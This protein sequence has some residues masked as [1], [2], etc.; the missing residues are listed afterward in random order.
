M[1][2]RYLFLLFI[3]IGSLYALSNEEILKRA[4][5]YMQSG[6]QSDQFRA[7]DDYKN[8]YLRAMVE[9]DSEL[10]LNSLR[11][12]V[13]SGNKLHIDV[14]RYSKELDKISPK[15]SYNKPTS[16]PNKKSKRAKDIHIKSSHKLTSI[17]WKDG[18]LVLDFDKKLRENQVN[19]FTLYDSK[20][21]IYKY[22]F[23]IHAS[24]LTKS[25]N[26]TKDGID[27]IKLAQ[28]KPDTLR[29]VI[30]NS[31]KIK[32][33]F[34]KEYSGL[35]IN[36]KSDKIKSIAKKILPPKRVDRSK[37]I[38]IDAGHGGRDPGAVGY[39]KYREKIVVFKIA[40]ELK[41]I[42]ISRGYK[43]Y[44]TRDRDKHVKL[45]RRTKFANEKNADIFISIHA[46]AVGKKNANKVNGIESYFLSP[47]R[48]SRA[49]K[50]AA[51]E[52]SAD[53]SDMNMYGKD[54]YL[55]LLNHH[56]IL[57]SNKLAIDLQRGMLG[58]L[59]KKYKNVKDGGVREGP[60]W[61]LVGAQMPSV[62][63]EVGFITHPMEAKRLVDSKYR[64]TMAKGMADGIER[65]FANCN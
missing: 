6:S 57:A 2:L 53:M 48:S 17:G 1:I 25:Q 46:N 4:D 34:K 49:K 60:F 58:S 9:D 28:Y 21:R 54:S 51:K 61:V 63:V 10:K 15:K 47:S 65:Y 32:V 42:L 7:Y 14:S 40:K 37:T 64:K 41:K 30:Q 20:K 16:V 62:L 56:N 8:L 55:N 18:R 44:M 38:V 24:M 33:N 45:S 36:I 23:D 27:R 26:I 5:N 13:K 39:K 29:L 22:V 12:I 19:Y 35:V 43:V 59:N 31:S 3:I 50:V 11:G 52:N